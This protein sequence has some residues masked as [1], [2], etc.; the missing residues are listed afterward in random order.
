MSKFDL[1][2]FYDL[3]NSCFCQSFLAYFGDAL[4]SWSINTS[5]SI[6]VTFFHYR[7][8]QTI[9]FSNIFKLTLLS[10]LFHNLQSRQRIFINMMRSKTLMFQNVPLCVACGAPRFETS[11]DLFYEYSK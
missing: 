7:V 3:R 4:I 9:M 1:S 8:I 5:L 11:N 10:P 6:I 2:L